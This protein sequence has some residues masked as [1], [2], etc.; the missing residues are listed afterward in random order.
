MVINDRP[1]QNLGSINFFSKNLLKA[2]I[3]KN[4]ISNSQ[5]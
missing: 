2:K 4:A 1:F 5:G 3:N